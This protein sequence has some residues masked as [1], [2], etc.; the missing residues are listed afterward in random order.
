[1]HFPTACLQ[2]I[3]CESRSLILAIVCKKNGHRWE[4]CLTNRFECLL[5]Y[6]EATLAF[7]GYRSRLEPFIFLFHLNFISKTTFDTVG[8]IQAAWTLLLLSL[9][10]WGEG[11]RE[12][13]TN[14]LHVLLTAGGSESVNLN[15]AAEE[16]CLSSFWQE[17]SIFC[18]DHAVKAPRRAAYG[19]DWWLHFMSSSEQGL[20]AVV[21][22][23][24]SSDIKVSRQERFHRFTMHFLVNI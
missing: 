17:T 15:V 14:D 2:I 19:A 18:R 3:K 23:S 7:W 9:Q 20:P 6:S 22:D 21:T 24:C 10:Y 4:H 1:M 13:T 11:G 12:G 8:M 16:M 5:A